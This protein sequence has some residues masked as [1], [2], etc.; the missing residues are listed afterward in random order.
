MVPAAKS[1]GTVR[2]QEV[3]APCVYHSMAPHIFA[4]VEAAVTV[5]TG[6]PPLP[7]SSACRWW[8]TRVGAQVLQEG[9]HALKTLPAHLAG[10]VSCIGGSMCRHMAPITQSGVVVLTTFLTLQVLLIRIV[11]LQ[12]AIQVLLPVVHFLTE[13]VGADTERESSHMSNQHKKG[14]NIRF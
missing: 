1:L 3:P 5:V 4:G 13:R 14:K 2:A 9:R 6:V 8:S 10:E 12:E 7:H 11:G